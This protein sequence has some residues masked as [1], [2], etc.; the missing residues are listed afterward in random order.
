MFLRYEWKR[1]K[2]IPKRCC[3]CSLPKRF[4][5]NLG[6]DDEIIRTAWRRA[7]RRS[8]RRQDEE[9]GGGGRCGV[10]VCFL[11]L[12]ISVQDGEMEGEKEGRKDGEGEKKGRMKR[13]WR[14]E[15]WRGREGWWVSF[16]TH[17][18]CHT[19]TYCDIRSKEKLSED[20]WSS[21]CFLKKTYN[22]LRFLSLLFHVDWN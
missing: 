9:G 17:I 15:G 20:H 5:R 4:V 18:I 19:R 8:K 16:F 7:W 3:C 13:E 14:K 12:S 21:I 10:R 6:Q 22:Y 2:K 11:L 1:N